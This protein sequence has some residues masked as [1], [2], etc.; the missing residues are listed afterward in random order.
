MYRLTKI[1]GQCLPM[2]SSIND[3]CLFMDSSLK[4]LILTLNKTKCEK[5]NRNVSEC[6]LCQ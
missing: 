5:N 4:K 2:N 6:K 1:N 3:Q